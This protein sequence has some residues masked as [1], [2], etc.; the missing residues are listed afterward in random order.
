MPNRDRALTWFS[1]GAALAVAAWAVVDHPGLSTAAPLIAAVGIVIGI[2]HGA[3]DHLVPGWASLRWSTPGRMVIVLAVYVAVAV[4][5]TVSLLLAPD[6]SF[7]VFLVVSAVHFGW[8]ETTFAAERRNDRARPLRHGWWEGVAHGCVVVVLPLWSAAGGAV[9]H[10][11]VPGLVRQ[12]DRIPVSSAVLGV[13]L[14]SAIT[15]TGMLVRR[16]GIEAVE[17]VTLL[18]LFLLAP[19]LAAFGVYFGLWHATRHTRRLMDQLAPDRPVFAQFGAFARSAAVPTAAAL[20]VLGLLWWSRAD[21]TVVVTGVT[22]LLALTFPHVV[23]VAV[24]DRH[25]RSGDSTRT[26]APR[27]RPRGPVP[28]GRR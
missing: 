26:G 17:L 2:P 6:L 18:L 14:V 19:P 24:L 25:R 16:R 27:R 15:V 12:V 21:S 9:L 10:P 20:S 5:A 8:A 13:A 7:A 23:V 22:V 3:V 28:C 11:L 1:T 4:A